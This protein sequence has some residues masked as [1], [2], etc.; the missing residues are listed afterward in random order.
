[1]QVFHDRPLALSLLIAILCAVA[2][3]KAPYGLTFAVGVFCALALLFLLFYRILSG[4]RFGGKR[5]FAVLLFFAV[6]CTTLSSFFFLGGRYARFQSLEKREYLIEGEVLER[7]SSLPFSTEY[8][9]KI[10]S[11]DGNDQSVRARLNCSYISALQVGDR[12]SATAEPV[13]F[14]ELEHENA[15]I[16][17]LSEESMLYLAQ[18]DPNGCQILLNEKESSDVWFSKLNYRLS[19]HLSEEIGGEEGDI[20]A[21]LLLGNRS[22]LDATTTLQFRRSG[23][24]HLLALSGLHVSVLIGAVEWFLRKLGLPKIAR[25][26]SVAVLAIGYLF[27]TGCSFSTVRAVLM[28][29]AVYI[30]FLLK[31]QNDSFTSLTIALFLILTFNPAAVYDPSLWMSFLATASIVIF[32]PVTEAPFEWLYQKHLFPNALFRVL[33]AFITALFVGIVAN[34]ALLLYS[35]YLFGELS[36]ASVLATLL[37]SLPVTGLLILSAVVLFLPMLPLLPDLCFLLGR[38]ILNVAG[39][40][41]EIRNILLP[42]IGMPTRFCLALLTLVLVLLAVLSL[43]SKWWTLLIPCLLAMTFVVTAMTVRLSFSTVPV[44]IPVGKGEVVLYAKQGDNVMVNRTSGNGNEAYQLKLAANASYCTEVS[45]LVFER[46]YNQATYF[47]NRLAEQVYVRTV[48][49]PPPKNETERAIAARLEQ[50]AERLGMKVVYQSIED[51][52]GLLD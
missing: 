12:F 16:T 31:A 47:L 27:L 9:V 46:Y 3:T 14:S 7:V 11:L 2:A 21:A 28:L 19:Y 22:F 29:C 52:E 4:K 41:S 18:Q 1:M 26:L 43:K 35:A 45:I 8:R 44:T 38:L 50:E 37:L 10:T 20:A 24:S 51:P 23:I 48:I 42:A 36:L 25:V 17:L 30:A 34:L 32:L 6:S 5:I 49:L 13:P 33:R 39:L 15:E 40:F